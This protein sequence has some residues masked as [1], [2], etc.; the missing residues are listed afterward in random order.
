VDAHRQE[1]AEVSPHKHLGTL[2]QPIF[3][4]HGIE[5]PIVPSFE[6][7][8]L[9]AEVPERVLRTAVIARVLRHAELR[10][11]L[12]DRWKLVHLV[13]QVIDAAESP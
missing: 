3:L 13:A 1:L 6:T 4:L 5:D 10:P 7:R 2:R 12:S 11:G 8:W 9:E